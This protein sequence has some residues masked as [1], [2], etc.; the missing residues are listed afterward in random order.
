MDANEAILANVE[1]RAGF[2]VWEP[3]VFTVAFPANISVTDA[4][5]LPL[6]GLRG[7]RQIALNAASLSHSAVAQVA[8]TPGLQSLVL[9][10]N[11]YSETEMTTLRVIGPEIVLA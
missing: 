10:N 5:V 1:A 4:D 11:H 6:T 9:F 7:V 8:G 3:E 2:Y